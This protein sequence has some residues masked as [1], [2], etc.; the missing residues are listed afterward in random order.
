[1]TTLA[2][3]RD[4]VEATLQDAG[5]ERWSTAD[6]DEAI[7]KAIEEY[8]HVD[9]HETITTITLSA[10]GR[11]IDISAVS[12][13]LA[14]TRVWWPYT[15]SDPTFPPN[16]STFE[17]WTDSSGAANILFIDA[18]SEP[19]AGDVVRLWYTSQHTLSGLDG[20]SSTTLPGDADAMLVTGA[21]VT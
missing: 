6:L 15:A 8:S 5:N 20:A 1:M 4:R 3:L 9:P 19:A 21:A 13:R 18:E 12:G 10:A 14:V 7:R 11:E 2:T 17:V 16:W